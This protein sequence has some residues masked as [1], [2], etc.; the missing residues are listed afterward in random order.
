MNGLST[1]EDLDATIARMERG[2]E[3]I[4]KARSRGS[5]VLLYAAEVDVLKSLEAARDVMMAAL[6]N[7]RDRGP[8]A[9][10]F[11]GDCMRIARIRAVLNSVEFSKVHSNDQ[12]NSLCSNAC[13]SVEDV[14]KDSGL[15][16]ALRRA[17]GKESDMLGQRQLEAALEEVG[18]TVAELGIV[19]KP[20]TNSANNLEIQELGASFKKESIESINACDPP[21]V[22]FG[23]NGC[24]EGGLGDVD[25]QEV[26]LKGG[27]GIDNCGG[28]AKQRSETTDINDNQPLVKLQEEALGP[29][30]SPQRSTD[31]P[32]SLEQTI[33]SSGDMTASEDDENEGHLAQPCESPAPR[34]VTKEPDRAPET[35]GSL[36]S[37]PS[38]ENM[39]RSAGMSDSSS[40]QQG[41]KPSGG[42]SQDDDIDECLTHIAA[43]IIAESEA[44]ELD[45]AGLVDGAIEQ[46]SL[47]EREIDAAT[48]ISL[49]AHE[50]DMA[51][52]SKHREAILARRWHLSGLSG[53]DQEPIPLEKQV[54]A[55]PLHIQ[56]AT[57]TSAMARLARAG[58]VTARAACTSLAKG[59]ASRLG[60]I[61]GCLLLGATRG[62]SMGVTCR[63]N[64][65]LRA[66]ETPVADYRCNACG[67]RYVQGSVL[68]GCYTCDYDLC[69]DCMGVQADRP[70]IRQLI[71]SGEL[72]SL[73]LRAFQNHDKK[74][75]R[76]LKGER[77]VAV[78]ADVFRGLRLE[79]PARRKIQELCAAANQDSTQLEMAECP[80]FIQSL[81]CEFC[82]I[83]EDALAQSQMDA[84]PSR[85]STSPGRS[86]PL[87]EEHA[88]MQNRLV[89]AIREGE[90]R[91]AAL[92]AFELQDTERLGFL[93][94][95]DGSIRRFVESVFEI[96]KL[97]TPTE[98]EIYSKYL[99]FDTGG[100]LRLD[101]CDR[102]R[103]V[104]MLCCSLYQ[105]ESEQGRLATTVLNSGALLDAAKAVFQ[106]QCSTRG[107]R[108]LNWNSGE[109]QAHV[110]ESF[111]AVGLEAPGEEQLLATYRR[112]S[113][114]DVQDDC[115][116][117]NQCVKLVESVCRDTHGSQA[118]D[119]MTRC[120]MG[121]GMQLFTTPAAD[122]SCN[123]CSSKFPK[124]SM[125]WSCRPCDF[126][127]CVQCS[128]Q[129]K[130]ME[131][132][133]CCPSGHSMSLFCT[134]APNYSCN[135][136]HAVFPRN[137]TLWSCRPCDFDMCS[138]CS[139]ARRRRNSLPTGK[140][141]RPAAR[142]SR[143]PRVSR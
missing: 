91:K 115:L 55:V 87:P 44:F 129:M 101:L 36:A 53:E 32:S 137:T 83:E 78:V 51:R 59:G 110:L 19:A 107:V 116:S 8:F 104:E 97:P 15:G 92:H 94:W 77:L 31:A 65:P 103:F 131:A 123:M 130:Q 105:L 24:V 86:V 13:R 143:G 126:D 82:G 26:N 142:L 71:M 6:R 121:H 22:K 60:T 99:I 66:F 46:Y 57:A 52:L 111:R 127:M 47:C 12:R 102:Y 56:A 128:K 138:R 11:G 95:N 98:G 10:L 69:I 16:D 106:K 42:R 67:R 93:E 90:L 120:P 124:G 50:A 30:T 75:A 64:H 43:A 136:C 141:F 39:S 34:S 23:D 20:K 58:S 134:P 5:A 28:E 109:V 62:G 88:A 132:T 61:A 81:C 118:S 122:F 63:A 17:Q 37:N 140:D 70:R 125:L 73:A 85:S 135:S 40:E 79:P 4:I 1:P 89:G 29:D 14:L 54:C 114:V 27:I 68:W 38:A 96:T 41:D 76:V 45:A 119:A 18:A 49:P 117:E 72:E 139:G 108:G 100:V 133:A 9:Q 113:F 84:T 48:R 2:L 21:H 3:S 112:L 25:V 35:Q 33:V 74:K 80:T 7:S